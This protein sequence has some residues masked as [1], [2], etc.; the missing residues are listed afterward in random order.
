MKGRS[1]F[2]KHRC[3]PRAASDARRNPARTAGRPFS[4]RRVSRAPSPTAGSEILAGLQTDSQTPGPPPRS[5][6]VRS[7]LTR[8]A[9]PRREEG[10]PSIG[11]VAPL[12]A[13]WRGSW[14]RPAPTLDFRWNRRGAAPRAPVAAKSQD[15]TGKG[16]HGA[17]GHDVN[18]WSSSGAEDLYGRQR[19]SRVRSA[20]LT[21]GF[22]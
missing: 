7:R 9:R 21:P 19:K 14:P 20:R 1:H 3:S 4:S 15:G 18:R 5:E 17:R 11:T 10:G 6:R 12:D 13:S 16:L 8:I 2:T 22:M